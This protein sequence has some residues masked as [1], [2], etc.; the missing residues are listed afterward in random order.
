MRSILVLQSLKV[1]QVFASPCYT[2][3]LVSLV[4]A[5]PS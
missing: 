4:L 1:S 3:T 2:R 5:L